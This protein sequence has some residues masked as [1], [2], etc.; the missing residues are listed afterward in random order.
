MIEILHDGPTKFALAGL[1][2]NVPVDL[3]PP[4]KYSKA[5]NAVSKIEGRLETRDGISLIASIIAATPIHTI[6]RLTQF[7]TSVVSERLVGIGSDL[8]TAPLPA[9]NAFLLLAGPTFDGSPLS[10]IQFRFDADP[11]VWAIIANANGMMKRRAGYYQVLGVAPPTVK[12]IATADGPGTLDSTTGTGYDWRYTYLNTVTLSES[13][14]SPPMLQPGGTFTKRPTG[15]DNPAVGGQDQF[16]NP[17]GAFDNN[18]VTFAD[19]LAAADSGSSQITSCRWKGVANVAGTAESVVLN[20]D[21]QAATNHGGLGSNTVRLEY[22]TDNGVTWTTIYST[23]TSRARATDTVN[24]P[25][26]GD[27]TALLVR[28]TV[29]A[30]AGVNNVTGNDA[31]SQVFEIYIVVTLQ[32]GAPLRLVLTNQSANVC[33]APPTD[34]QETA[35]RLYRRGGTLPNNWFNVGQFTISSLVQ[36]LCGTGTLLINDNIPDSQAQLGAILPQD[37]F[38]PIQSVQA[39]NFP[40]PVI[41]GPSDGRVLGCGDPARPDAVYFSARGNADQWGAESWVTVANP[42][43]QVMNGL[44]YNLRTFAFTRERM[45][46]MLP[47]IIQGITFTPAETACRRGLKG[48]WGFTSG[49]QGI[50]FWS[51]DGIY[52][53]SGGPE[54]SIIDDSIRPLFPTREAPTGT[55]TNGYDS[56]NMD[57]EDGLRMAF[58]NGE[59][60]CYYTGATTGLRQLMI[61]DERR[62]RWRP[63]TY[64]PRMQMA[65]SEPNT[66]SSL[67]YGGID[68]SLYAAGGDDDSNTPIAVSI[69]TGAF[70][71]QRPL[72]L[73][74]YLTLN[75]DID[76]GGATAASPIVVTPRL[77]GETLADVAINIIGSGRQRASLPL[78]DGWVFS[79]PGAFVYNPALNSVRARTDQASGE[80]AA[81]FN[82]PV[83]RDHFIEATIAAIGVPGPAGNNS[84]QNI[85]ARMS[86]DPV[87]G[88]ISSYFFGPRHDGGFTFGWQY[89]VVPGEFFGAGTDSRRSFFPGFPD[90]FDI[91]PTPGDVIRLEVAGNTVTAKRNGI[92][93]FGPVTDTDAMRLKKITG[94]RTGID[95]YPENAT[96]STIEQLSSFR[97]GPLPA[98]AILTPNIPSVG[99]EVYAYN[100]EFDV[101]WNAAAAI[102]P[103]LY[104]YETLY[105]HEPA[106]VTHWELPRSS[107]GQQGW[108]H[109]RDMYIVLRST[110]PVTLTV[111]PDAG[112]SQIFTL[113]STYGRKQTIYVK[114]AASKANSYAFAI[115]SAKPFRMYNEECEV[116]VKQWLTKLGYQNVPLIAKE[117]IGSMNV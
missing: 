106:E 35:I 15:F 20:I 25:V 13:N 16:T 117:Q 31:E 78:N 47:N 108:F 88:L 49:E 111:A 99:G 44:V 64:T 110:A 50:Y 70:D 12:A 84:N 39:V 6:F 92:I 32:A 79:E 40:L 90:R 30:T 103:I 54:Q 89:D 81:M 83:T 67:L 95:A 46:I 17:G 19:G 73:K 21:S 102:K 3:V 75:L 104:Q 56:I 43:E 112:D 113:P 114:L 24:L 71:Q 2:L 9:G 1:D 27:L 57:D 48:R 23:G 33:V 68:G 109:I 7:N 62:S 101:T 58:H 86:I 96:P 37:N 63:G 91:N 74:E 36:G 107:M 14:G 8:Y 93:V 60:W 116:R 82:T 29:T 26:G 55:P 76:P 53:T 45:H 52:R 94:T 4:N 98:G 22:S 115:D 38:Q 105:R 61:Y 65:Y 59:I 28:S 85:M 100:I 51:K 97:T 34:P 18:S 69:T 80:L 87:T 77:N 41:F 10:I 66:S 5:T 42:G 72:N 11:A